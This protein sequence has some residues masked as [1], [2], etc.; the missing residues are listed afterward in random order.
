MPD[1]KAAIIEELETSAQE[2]IAFYKS[3]SSQQLNTQVY[4]SE[5]SWNVRQVLAHFVT[6]EQSMQWLFNDILN[7]GPGSPEDFDVQ[8]F[9]RSQPQKLD[10]LSL[11][12]LIEKFEAVRL[13][14]IQIVEG[15]TDSDLD[16]RGRHAFHGPGKL[17]RFI[18][19]AYEHARL[20]EDDMREAL[21]HI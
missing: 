19:W 2:T 8:R 21:K 11:E 20:H 1:R 9:N 17:E 12:Q 3:L 7:G 5:V 4:R 14:T 16:R 6:I 13:Q 18:R 10:G 15:M